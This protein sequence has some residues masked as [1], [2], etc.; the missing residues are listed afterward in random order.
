MTNDTQEKFYGCKITLA[1][2]E[3]VECRA[4]VILEA[5]QKHSTALL[6]VGDP[7]AYVCMYVRVCVCVCVWCMYVCV[8]VCVYDVY[9][10]VCVYV[11]MCVC[12]YDV[13]VCVCVCMMCDV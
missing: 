6:I 1:D 13:Y 8:C 7:F 3:F 11:N 9:V 4:D 2:R 5:A 10:C 12:V